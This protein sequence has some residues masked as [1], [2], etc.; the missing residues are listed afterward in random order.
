MAKKP[1]PVIELVKA[2]EAFADQYPEGS[3]EDF[4]SYMLAG[5]RGGESTP[6]M[7]APAGSPEQLPMGTTNALGVLISRLNRYLAFYTRKVIK[8]LP[9]DNS[10]DF[11]YLAHLHFDGP[12]RKSELI[13][14][15]IS[16]FTSGTNVINRLLKQK[17]ILEYEDPEDAR[18]KRVKITQP[19]IDWINACLPDMMSV[20][21]LLLHPLPEGEKWTAYQVLAKVD[22]FHNGY[23]PAFRNL[24]LEK[25]RQQLGREN[26]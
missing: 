11:Y 14:R 3:L 6:P 20:Y 16:E 24:P 22:H 5:R 17:F 9:V 25:I 19:G 26:G 4:Y 21:Q 15:N 18:S 12:L 7:E 10:E 8:E 23:Y 2:W 1:N 13:A